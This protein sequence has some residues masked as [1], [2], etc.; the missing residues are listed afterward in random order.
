MT[1][2]AL[3]LSL[4]PADRADDFERHVRPMLV[5]HCLKCHGDA[6]PKGGL[7]LTSRAALLKGGDSGPAVVPGDPERSL[8]VRA[9]RY[10]DDGTRMPPASKMPRADIDRLTEARHQE[11]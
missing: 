6:K 9:V 11:P 8:L 1:A 4:A 7:S 3:L 10:L 2:F 5:A